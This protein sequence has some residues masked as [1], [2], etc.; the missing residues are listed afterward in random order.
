MGASNDTQLTATGVRSVL[1]L[2][3]AS[4]SYLLASSA[5]GTVALGRNGKVY[6]LEGATASEIFTAAFGDP[7]GLTLALT[8]DGTVCW[9]NASGEGACRAVDAT[10]VY[11]GGEVFPSA[12]AL[13]TAG[14]FYSNGFKNADNLYRGGWRRD[15]GEQIALI[16]TTPV[17]SIPGT[18]TITVPTPIPG[19][20][21]ISAQGNIL[22]A[23][24][25]G[26][27]D[28]GRLVS[29]EGA[30]DPAQNFTYDVLGN[31]LSEAA[32][33]DYHEPGTFDFSS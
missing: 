19:T 5:W 31:R 14:R 8:P 24:R 6:R 13:D 3:A 12:L 15:P 20:L 17:E 26:Y 11:L 9:I 33:N 16:A 28:A 2:P 4:E 29:E 7:W 21:S 25:Y 23:R 30:P 1:T 27:D 22:E 18:L 32:A 10:Q